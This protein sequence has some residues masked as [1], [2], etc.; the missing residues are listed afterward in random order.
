L[1]HS[2]KLMNPKSLSPPYNLL[3]R[4]KSVKPIVPQ[5]GTE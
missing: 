1:Q 3:P 2:S 5:S 4:K